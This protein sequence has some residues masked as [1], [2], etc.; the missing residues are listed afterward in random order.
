MEAPKK[1]E[2]LGPLRESNRGE[3]HG[4]KVKRKLGEKNAIK[5]AYLLQQKKIIGILPFCY[6]KGGSNWRF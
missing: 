6:R 3:R 2:G 4:H 1:L 5:G